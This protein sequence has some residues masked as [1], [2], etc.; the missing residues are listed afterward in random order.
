[1]LATLYRDQGQ[2][3]KA[4]PLLVEA[5]VEAR[6]TYGLGHANTQTMLS[7]LTI[8]YSKKG[9]PERAEPLLREMVEFLR[10]HPGEQSDLLAKG[11]ERLAGNMLEQKKYTQAEQ[12]GRECLAL[13]RVEEPPW[14]APR[15][16]AERV[17]RRRGARTLR[18]TV[19][20]RC[21]AILRED[22]PEPGAG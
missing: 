16:A 19:G 12:C 4:E 13:R 17:L 1:N 18:V 3:D 21:G 22:A 9:T 20:R 10:E 11:L 7:H 5:V 8:L 15:G 14:P 2:H 6:K